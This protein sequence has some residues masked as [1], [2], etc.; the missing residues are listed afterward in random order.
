[1]LLTQTQQESILPLLLLLIAKLTLPLP[2]LTAPQRLPMR[3]HTLKR[4]VTLSTTL[5]GQAI[6]APASQATDLKSAQGSAS[7]SGSQSPKKFSLSSRS[8]STAGT[9]LSTMAENA[10]ATTATFE[11][12]MASV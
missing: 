6:D 4:T 2:L 10:S 9:T 3:L 11:T 1:M 5:I 8:Q 7:R 12:S